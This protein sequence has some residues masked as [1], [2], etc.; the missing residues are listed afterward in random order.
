MTGLEGAMLSPE[1]MS[2]M[3]G[4]N[5]GGGGGAIG[6]GGNPGQMQSTNMPMQSGMRMLGQLGE[7]ARPYVDMGLNIAGAVQKRKERENSERERK[8]RREMALKQFLLD[9]QWQAKQME[10]IR[11]QQEGQRGLAR[12]LFR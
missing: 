2:L 10:E 6:G 4:I 8:F 3:S 7:T 1:T 11:R 12:G 9:Q 5:S